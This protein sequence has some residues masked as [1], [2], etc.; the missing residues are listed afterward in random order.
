MS[1]PLNSWCG[2]RYPHVT[3]LSQTQPIEFLCRLD[4]DA[5]RGS[6][7]ASD[8]GVRPRSVVRLLQGAGRPGNDGFALGIATDT[9]SWPCNRSGK[10]TE[11]LRGTQG[12]SVDCDLIDCACEIVRPAVA[13]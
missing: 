10:V 9:Q 7:V 2:F 4:R 3:G 6:G 11:H 13:G 1:L 8:V 5:V 12:L